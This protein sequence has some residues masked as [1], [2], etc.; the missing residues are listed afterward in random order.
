MFWVE[1]PE[2]KRLY[3]NFVKLRTPG[4][5]WILLVLSCGKWLL[6]CNDVLR[7]IWG[8]TVKFNVVSDDAIW[9]RLFPFSLKEKVN[10]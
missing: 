8:V 10:H 6:V 5:L 2:Q 3:P 9:L 1:L 4:H 7:D